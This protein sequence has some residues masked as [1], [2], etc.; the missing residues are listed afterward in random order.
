[1]ANS[2]DEI[3]FVSRLIPLNKKHP[4]IPNA[5]EFRPIIVMSS[6]VKLLE[7]RLLKKLQSYTIEKLQRS[8]V[9][10]VNGMD[11]YVNIHRAINQLKNRTLKKKKGFCLFLDFKSAYKTI[12]HEELFQ[13]LEPICTINEIQ[14]L[15]AIY[16]RLVLKLGSES[17][18][19]NIGVA[20]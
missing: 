5:D 19:C 10:F 16:S 3:H 18:K 14:L 7:A 12:P 15:R 17:T 4:N 13:K 8:Q 1:M 20:I 2:L 11:I 9:S 6:L